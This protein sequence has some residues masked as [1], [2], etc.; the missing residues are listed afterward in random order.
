MTYKEIYD[1][2]VPE[3]KRKEERVNVFVTYFV[4]PLSIVF[5][6]L[7]LNTQ[8]SPIFITKLSIVCLI[9]AFLCMLLSKCLIGYVIGWVLVF[10]WSI[11]D[12]VDGN[13]ARC[14]KQCSHLGDMW[15]TLGGYLAMIVVYFSVGIM[16]YHDHN[17]MSFCD[18]YYLIVLG[19]MTA[20]F[21]ILPRLMMHKK[22]SSKVQSKAVEEI[23]DSGNFSLSKAIA[24][25]L[26]SPSGIMQVIVLICILTHTLNFFILFYC[27]VN[28]AVMIVSLKKILSEE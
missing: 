11:L 22:K 14:K 27:V 1:I 13:I 19:G 15:D 21:C 6:K 23:S 4:R 24:A 18:D 3:R 9:V 8:A 17:L 25:N 10:I 28:F 16:S 2:A 26:I 7:L 5:T 20:I 12:G